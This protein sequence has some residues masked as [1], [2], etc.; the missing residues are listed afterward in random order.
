MRAWPSQACQYAERSNTKPL[1]MIANRRWL[2]SSVL[3][4]VGC[5]DGPAAPVNTVPAAPTPL[6]SAQLL[7]VAAVVGQSVSL[8]VTGG[9]TDRKKQGLTYSVSF[10]PSTTT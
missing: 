8:D 1:P 4:S 9:F 5:G 2:L 6:I 3:L 10:T 7:S